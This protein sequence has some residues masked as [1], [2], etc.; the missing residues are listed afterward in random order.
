[1]AERCTGKHV[2]GIE[3]NNG[4]ALYPWLWLLG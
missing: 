2:Q 3:A 1:M 4:F